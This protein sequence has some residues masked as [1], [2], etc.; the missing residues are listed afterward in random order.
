MFADEL[1][2]KSSGRYHLKFGI[3]LKAHRDG[4]KNVPYWW[5]SISAYPIIMC[6][7]KPIT[8]NTFSSRV[9]IT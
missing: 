5:N 2:S 7:I 6:N 4:Y 3:E 9:A 1:P 8:N